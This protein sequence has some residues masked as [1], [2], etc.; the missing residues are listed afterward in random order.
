MGY[1]DNREFSTDE[2]LM[3]KKH[4]KKCLTSLVI[5]EVQ[6]KTNLRL[7]LTSVRMKEKKSMYSSC[8]HWGE[9][10]YSVSGG[11]ANLYKYFGNQFGSF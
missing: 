5:R 2:S 11:S 8:W 9:E 6:I 7:Y 3:A 1:R 4:L 10:H